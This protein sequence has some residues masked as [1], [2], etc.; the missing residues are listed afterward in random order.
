M[1]I[2]D[3]SLRLDLYFEAYYT[4]QLVDD[5][6]CAFPEVLGIFKQPLQH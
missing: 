5:E 6:I 4:K 3:L 2:L 1:M